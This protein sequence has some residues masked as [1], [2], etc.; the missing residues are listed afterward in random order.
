L[1][2]LLDI[3]APLEERQ[4][5]AKKKRTTKAK[6]KTTEHIERLHEP[7]PPGATRAAFDRPEN[8]GGGPPGS[9]AGDRHAAG[10]PA[11]GT[12]VGG[13]A[14][15]NI[16]DGDPDNADLEARMAGE[17]ED[18]PE[19][20]PPYAGFSGGAVG[21]TPAELRSKGGSVH[22]GIDPG[23]AHRG[24]STIGSKPG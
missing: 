2:S 9:G 17:V 18:E 23:A 24:D 4:I 13:L 16:D 15:T 5:M 11:G 20:G 7:V 6:K 14:G 3:S 22:R 10:T 8:P 21:G 19:D 1:K 12:D